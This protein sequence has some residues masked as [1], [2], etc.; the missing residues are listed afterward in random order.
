MCVDA[1][2]AETTPKVIDDTFKEMTTRN[3]IGIVLITQT[4]A[5]QIRHTVNNFS[6]PI[7]AILEIP[8]KD[9]PYDV[10]KDGI[11][12]CVSVTLPL[13]GNMNAV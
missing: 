6:K 12:R 8:S 13:Q 1:S 11:L 5:E 3:D 4:C 2:L 10:T 7:P 9:S